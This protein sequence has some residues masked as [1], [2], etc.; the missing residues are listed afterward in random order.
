MAKG[1]VFFKGSYR[2]QAGSFNAFKS[3]MGVAAIFKSTSGWQD[4]KYYALMNNVTPG[5]IVR[6][7]NTNNNRIIFAKVLGELPPGREN[8]GLIIRISNA[9][10][11]ELRISD[12]EPKFAAEVAYGKAG[13]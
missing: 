9:A 12:K 13:R 8:E 4:A 10:A 2:E 11:A 5:T 3:E 6:I 1:R 7:T